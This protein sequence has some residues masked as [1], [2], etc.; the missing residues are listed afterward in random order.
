MPT[1][2]ETLKRR[3]PL[4]D[5]L[6]QH[7]WTARQAGSSPEYVGLCPLHP[8]TRP[9]F[10]VNSRKNLFYCHG[11][12]GGGDLL[13][14]VQLALN[15]SL[16]DS[17][18]HLEQELPAVASA[19]VDPVLT[20]ALAFYQDQLHRHDEAWHYLQKRGLRDP[21][22]IG[23]LGIGYAPGGSLRRH[24]SAA[25][26]PFERLREIGLVNRH[27]GDAFWRR[28]VF[29]CRDR[30]LLVNLY[31][32]SIEGAPPHRFL[33]GPKGGLFAWETVLTSPDVILVE[34]FFD[35]ALLWQ[36]G[37]IN[38]TC[39][40]G[41]HLTPQQFSQLCDAPGRQVFLAFDADSNGAGPAAA[42]R[43]AQCLQQAG[44]T[45]RIVQLPPGQD[46]NSYLVAGASAPDFARCL[47][48]A[49]SFRR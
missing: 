12:G 36:A 14:F 5:Y 48:Q 46:P 2:L 41:T 21:G 23:R 27:G 10:Y 19:S 29:P 37:F 44:L 17:V 22:L 32:R 30:G 42:R 40:G 4:L 47:D 35:V 39:A 13:R 25:R 18:T 38:T 15:L 11:C 31:G 20:D 9:S 34:G 6:K 7:G 26:H 8:E 24:L 16:R 49:E 33:P 3:F 1:Q 28:I 45:A 43:L